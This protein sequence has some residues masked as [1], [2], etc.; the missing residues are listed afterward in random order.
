MKL[1]K[2]DFYIQG[3]KAFLRLEKSLSDNSV[4]AYLHDVAL[5][6]R[7]IQLQQQTVE[8]TDIQLKFLQQFVHY[9]HELGL[10]APSQ[11]RIISGIKSFL[12]IYCLKISYIPI[13]L[14]YWKPPNQVE[15]SLILYP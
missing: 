9:I 10:S 2:T 6:F 14:N 1:L 7:F 15:N 8:I 11:S 3:F 5:L 12:V 13:Q 4:Q